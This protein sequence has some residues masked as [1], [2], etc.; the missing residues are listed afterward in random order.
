M[1][2][3]ML[4]SFPQQQPFAHQSIMDDN[5]NLFATLQN[6]HQLLP[7]AIQGMMGG[8]A[9]HQFANSSS[10]GLGGGGLNMGGMFSALNTGTNSNFS[11]MPLAGEANLLNGAQLNTT[12]LSGNNN[13][14]FFLQQQQQ[15]QQLQFEQQQHLL[16]QQQQLQQQLQQNQLQLQQFQRQAMNFPEPQPQIQSPFLSNA[17]SPLSRPLPD[18]GKL[19][20]TNEL[21]CGDDESD[22]APNRPSRRPAN[23][24]SQASKTKSFPEKLMS[25]MQENRDEDVVGWLPDGKSF[26][27]V[28]P[29]KF[30]NQVLGK[31]AKHTTKYSSFVRKLHRS[32]VVVIEFVACLYTAHSTHWCTMAAGDLFV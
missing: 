19:S 20:D 6:Q 8:S 23:N 31:E 22:K 10:L 28:S 9:L 4:G 26:V 25:A 27:I 2:T 21:Q 24:T 30:M 13:P 14:S 18:I 16:L 7:Q 29:E 1:N 32:V 3:N 11:T 15:Q 12:F 5:T 17:N